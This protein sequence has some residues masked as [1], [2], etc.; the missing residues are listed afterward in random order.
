LNLENGVHELAWQ[1]G[2]ASYGHRIFYN[3]SSGDRPVNT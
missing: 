3:D 2:K 1:A